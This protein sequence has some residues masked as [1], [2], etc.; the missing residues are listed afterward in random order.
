VLQAGG[1]Q[2]L[3]G[4][5]ARGATDVLTA[6]DFAAELGQRGQRVV[7][8]GELEM[9]ARGLCGCGCGHRHEG[10]QPEGSY[11]QSHGALFR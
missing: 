2:R 6:H 9:L 11:C 5:A 10:E 7:A 1:G 8:E 3:D 4:G